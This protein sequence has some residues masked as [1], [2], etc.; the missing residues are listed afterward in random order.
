MCVCVCVCVRACVR[1][2]ALAAPRTVNPGFILTTG[3]GGAR[4]RLLW[5]AVLHSCPARKTPLAA[6][7][8]HSRPSCPPAGP[9]RQP[10]PRSPPLH[11]GPTGLALPAFSPPRSPS[12]KAQTPTPYL[13]PQLIQQASGSW[14]LP[15]KMVT[16]APAP[17]L[18]PRLVH[19]PS[20]SLTEGSSDVSLPGLMAPVLPSIQGQ[21]LKPS[22]SLWKPQ[23]GPWTYHCKPK[24]IKAFP[25]S[26]PLH[27]L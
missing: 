12:H 7:P 23:P 9:A 5:A 22:L 19:S 27:R 8:S 13:E 14:G 2:C 17:I 25:T 16:E 3:R 21:R 26:G 24:G 10:V 18:A 1:A 20:R 6:L 4:G 15:P 11:A